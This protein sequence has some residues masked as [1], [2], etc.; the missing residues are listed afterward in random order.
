MSLKNL[1][2]ELDLLDDAI[3]QLEDRRTEI[4]GRIEAA[5]QRQR[6]LSNVI[7]FP[8][9]SRIEVSVSTST[10]WAKGSIG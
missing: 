2:E 1:N 10:E 7:A 9:P 5:G 4:M 6:T 3:V 8:N